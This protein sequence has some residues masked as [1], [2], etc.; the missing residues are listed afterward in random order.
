MLM[1]LCPICNKTIA[2]SSYIDTDD[3]EM[4]ASI[5]TVHLIDH[6]WDIVERIRATTGDEQARYQLYAEL[7]SEMT[8]H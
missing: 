5:H 4:I 8:R 6:H 7:H 2:G 1:L 3:P